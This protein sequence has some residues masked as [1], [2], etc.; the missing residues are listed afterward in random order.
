MGII[1]RD[2]GGVN[3][4]ITSM[5]VL[6][7]T[8]LRTVFRVKVQDG[9]TLRTV[10]T[11]SPAMTASASPISVTGEGSNPL[12]IT[13][14]TNATTVTPA[15]GTSPYTYAWT[16]V[17]YDAGAVPVVNS[18]TSASTTFRQSMVGPSDFYSAVFRCTVTDGF[19]QTA[20]AD[21]DATFTNS[22]FS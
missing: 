2:A 3:R 17:S 22:D 5:K 15:G 12:P 7:G 11:F 4:T 14:T 18:P 19:G 16:V 21:V 1:A 10:A 20:T 13:I 6:D 8:L 9:A